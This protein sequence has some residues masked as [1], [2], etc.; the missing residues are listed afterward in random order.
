MTFASVAFLIVG[1]FV[2][3]VLFAA[4][5]VFIIRGRRSRGTRGSSEGPRKTERAS[6]IAG[7]VSMVASLASL[8]FTLNPSLVPNAQ[9]D[10]DRAGDVAPGPSEDVSSSPSE[11]GDAQQ[12][13]SQQTDAPEVI[14]GP[15]ETNS[16]CGREWTGPEE[17]VWRVCAGVD[18][19]SVFFGLL[20]TNH[21]SDPVTVAT[22]LE[23]ARSG[24]FSPCPGRVGEQEETIPA[25][26]QIVVGGAQ[27][28][29][30][31][32]DEQPRTYQGQGWVAGVQD[33]SVTDRRSPTAHV[34]P[35][36]DAEDV[37]WVPKLRES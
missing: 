8:L 37:E 14:S 16:I 36:Q 26:E 35:G 33:A 13:G 30:Q 12:G 6:W 19:E 9:G 32:E 17:A 15:W 18:D 27:C 4:G 28:T 25:G 11:E 29:V 20:I 1:F 2:T 23:Y 7:I 34:Y 24:D 31:R 21:G 22:N 3:L 5:V 10:E